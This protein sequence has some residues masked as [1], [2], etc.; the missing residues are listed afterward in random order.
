[1][2]E[3]TA[4]AQTGTGGEGPPDRGIARAEGLQGCTA[5]GMEQGKVVGE[6]S[7]ERWW[8]WRMPDHRYELG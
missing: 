5:A 7:S 2:T 4:N 3:V 6:E 1:M 8:E